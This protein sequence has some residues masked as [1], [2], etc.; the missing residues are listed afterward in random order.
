MSRVALLHPELNPHVC[1][2]HYYEVRNLL[3]VRP[4]AAIPE[5]PPNRPHRV[6]APKYTA[7]SAGRTTRVMPVG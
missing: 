2:A 5:M 3:A 7:D 4:Y 1:P 6:I